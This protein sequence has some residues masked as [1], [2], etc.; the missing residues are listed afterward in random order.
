MGT[1]TFDAG[2]VYR[3]FSWNPRLLFLPSPDDEEEEEEEEE[4]SLSLSLL[5]RSLLSLSR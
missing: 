1:S 3:A 5:S 2:A 4:L